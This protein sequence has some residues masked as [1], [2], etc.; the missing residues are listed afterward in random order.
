MQ[1]IQ[2]EEKKTV[3]NTGGEKTEKRLPLPSFVTTQSLK[4]ISKKTS[5]QGEV[6][7]HSTTEEL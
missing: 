2:K 6:F 5:K 7:K 4:P 3:V 1:Q